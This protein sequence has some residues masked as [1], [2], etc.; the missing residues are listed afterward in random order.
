MRTI[1]NI[2]RGWKFIQEDAGLPDKLP[3]DWTPVDLPH[4]WNAVDGHDGNGSYDRGCYWY[5]RT[6]ETPT[7]PL[8]GGRVFVDIPAAGQ[9]ARVY[10][11][12]KEIC[13]HEGGYSTFRADITEACKKEGENLLVVACSNEHKSNVYPQSADFTFYGGLYRGMNLISV[14][15]THFEL[16]YWGC[17]GLKVT[18]TP[19]ECGGAEFEMES[20]VANADENFTVFYRICDAEGKEVGYCVRPADSTAVKLYV[21]DVVL[22]DCDNP[23]LYTVTA[24]L[25]RRNEVYDTVMTRVGVRSFSCDADKGFILNGIPTPLRGVSRHQD[26]LYKGNALTRE[27][28]YQDARIIKELGANTIRLAHYQHSQDFYDA[29]DELGFIVWAEIP[30]ISVMS[31]DPAAH[32][33]CI[34]QMKE[35]IIQNYNHP[36]I[37][38]WGVSN[39]ILIGGIS[40]QLV[41]NHK[42]LNALCKKLDPTRLTTIAHVSMT[43]IDSPVHNI[44][45]VESY[46][47][48]FGWYGGKMEDNGPWLDNFHKEHPE[49][50]L[51]LSEYGCEGIITYHGPD[52]ACKDYSEEYQA[53]YHEHM[54]KVLDERP[55]MW[56]SHVWNMF[57]FGCAARNEGGVAGR[58]NKGLVTMDRC[59]RKDSYYIYKAYW[60]KEPMVHLCGKRYAQRAGGTTQIRVY[61]NQ[62]TVSLFIN[63]G[64]TEVQ[65]ADKVFVFTVALKDGFNSILAL[66]GNCKDS[67][68]L[69]KVEKE[70]DIYVLPEVN[71]RA[72]GVANWFKL[73]GD[74]DL[75]AP[76][77]FP[78]G[79]YSI[80]CTMEEIAECPEA[81]E[82]VAKAVKLAT[83][84]EMKPGVGMWDMVKFTRLE[85]VVQMAGNMMP[86]GFVE[87]LNAQLIKVDKIK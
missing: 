70:P 44:T 77:E 3:Q 57:D 37:C 85:D 59:T 21:P 42:E 52:P 79:K 65:T 63:G 61:S 38:F 49:I 83:N 47:H 19:S 33:N 84:M 15:D 56:S 40:E 71:E 80:K 25:Q 50:C 73:A 4:T 67:M 20:W 54:A 29:C 76:M 24:L 55:W 34:T 14:P 10:V 86:E 11:N 30:F 22:W 35:L 23:Y 82:I 31:Q 53:L 68:T 28:H 36:S 16:S 64:L 1:I 81:I 60:N 46:N 72:E 87:S 62:P 69:E 32:Q 7:Q 12:G 58:N 66:A 51:G 75:K 26:Q 6:F 48:Y 74:L 39:E 27:D 13:Y 5:A 17:N 41:E 18:A 43:P 78:E 8:S 45:D 9:Q 2:N